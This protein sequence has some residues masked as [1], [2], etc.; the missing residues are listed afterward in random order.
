MKIDFKLIM[1]MR[2]H[3][4]LIITATNIIKNNN[5]ETNN[6]FFDKKLLTGFKK[7]CRS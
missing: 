4:E 1:A 5:N 3:Y 6:I 2:S 7:L